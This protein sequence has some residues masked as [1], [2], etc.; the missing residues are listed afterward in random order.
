MEEKKR[1]YK[2][3]NK[4]QFILYFSLLITIQLILFFTLINIGINMYSL[5]IFTFLIFLTPILLGFVTP[6]IIRIIY[7]EELKKAEEEN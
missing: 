6:K 4:R 7:K 2:K 3:I 5:I 1:I